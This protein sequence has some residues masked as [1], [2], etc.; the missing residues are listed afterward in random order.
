MPVRAATTS[1]P[2]V[3]NIAVTRMFVIKPKVMKIACVNVPYRALIIS[4]KVYA[5]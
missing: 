3:N 4:R 1:A 5:S 2:P